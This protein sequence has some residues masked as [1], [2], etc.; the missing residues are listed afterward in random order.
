MSTASFSAP[1]PVLARDSVPEFFKRGVG[2]YANESPVAGLLWFEFDRRCVTLATRY[3]YGEADVIAIDRGLCSL[4]LPVPVTATYGKMA[5]LIADPAFVAA[6]DAVYSAKTPD[7]SAS[8]IAALRTA[9]TPHFA[10]VAFT[11][12]TRR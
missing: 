11:I 4:F 6:I 1:H 12:Y 3:A 5:D 8:A 10:D 2:V 9:Y 7:A